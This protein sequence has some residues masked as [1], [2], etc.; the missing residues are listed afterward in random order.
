MLCTRVGWW[1]SAAAD[2]FAPLPTTLVQI[3]TPWPFFRGGI[4][5]MLMTQPSPHYVPSNSSV[6]VAGGD[7]LKKCSWISKN[8]LPGQLVC[9]LWSLTIFQT[10]ILN[11]Y[12]PLKTRKRANWYNKTNLS[13]S[14]VNK[15]RGRVVQQRAAVSPTGSC[16]IFFFNFSIPSLCWCSL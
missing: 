10:K 9:F 1:T 14:L 11:L 6:C 12:Y 5:P 2:G 13:Q 15:W 4:L 8:K 3:F 7:F 16:W